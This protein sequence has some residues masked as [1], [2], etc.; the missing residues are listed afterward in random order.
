MGCSGIL[1]TYKTGNTVRLNLKYPFTYRAFLSEQWQA[2]GKRDERPHTHHGT[3]DV[4]P[5]G[6]ALPVPKRALCSW[7]GNWGSLCPCSAAGRLMHEEVSCIHT[8]LGHWWA[9]CSRL[10]S[11]FPLPDC[12]LLAP[13]A[14]GWWAGHVPH[15]LKPCSQEAT[16]FCKR[17]LCLS[18]TFPLPLQK[19]LASI[20]VQ[21][22]SMAP[23]AKGLMIHGLLLRPSLTFLNE[24][25]FCLFP[26]LL[27]VW[28]TLHVR[29]DGIMQWSKSNVGKRKTTLHV[30]LQMLG[31]R[32]VCH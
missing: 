27:Q 16:L 22:G 28:E 23:G 32:H 7:I 4:C 11:G 24:L 12:C 13:R 14:G 31:T 1:P 15:A 5:C 18:S 3:A 20:V 29:C 8:E 10:S 2:V 30:I 6:I 9:S 21:G 25:T 26:T 19:L 17:T